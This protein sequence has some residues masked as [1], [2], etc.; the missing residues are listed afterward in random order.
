MMHLK[1]SDL[2]EDFWLLGFWTL[3]HREGE[4]G[5]EGK[6]KCIVELKIEEDKYHEIRICEL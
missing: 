6:R 4:E 1:A 2:R 3:F 5:E